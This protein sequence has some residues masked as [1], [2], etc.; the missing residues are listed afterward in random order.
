V[1][2][3]ADWDD[4]IGR[5]LRLR[6][7]RVFFAVMQA[8]SLTKAAAHLHVSHPAVSQVIADLEHSLGV[9]LFDRSRRGV[10][11][12]V[13][14]RAFFAHGQA[15]FDDLRQGMREIEFLADPTAGELTIGYTLSIADTVLPQIVERFYEE[16]PRV[17]M[18][19]NIVPTPAFKFPGLSDRT[20]DLILTRIPAPTPNDGA[21]NDLNVE[22]LFDDPWVLAASA[23]SRWANRRKVDLA[24]LLKEPW[25]MPP[26]DTSAHK[27][28][29][30]AFKARG[31]PMPTATLMTYSMDLRVKSSARGRFITVVPKSVLRHGDDRHA[32][33]ELPVAIPMRPWP[34]AILTLK[35]RTLSPVVDRFIGCAREVAKSFAKPLLGRVQGQNPNVS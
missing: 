9:K 30:E 7:L 31:L 11:P 27:V 32:L 12:T 20:Y 8:G 19:A 1:A 18:R 34:V 23:S 6:D 21:L 28:V 4:H 33:R 13:Y 24:E 29:A 25:I 15:A 3:I 14:A 16:Y 35:N 2:K 22:V 10:V 5:R 17:V 26:P